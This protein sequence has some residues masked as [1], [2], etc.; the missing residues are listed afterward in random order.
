MDKSDLIYAYA[1]KEGKLYTGQCTRTRSLSDAEEDIHFL[2]A[3]SGPRTTTEIKGDVQQVV[4]YSPWS[5]R[6]AAFRKHRQLASPEF[7]PV[8]GV[9]LDVTRKPEG[10]EAGETFRVRT[11]TEGEFELVDPKPGTYAAQ[12]VA[13]GFHIRTYEHQR[14]GTRLRSGAYPLRLRENGCAEFNLVRERVGSVTVS[15]LDAEGGPLEDTPEAGLFLAP[16]DYLR[17]SPRR[18]EPIS[19]GVFRFEEVP[20]GRYH[21]EVGFRSIPNKRFPYAAL[22]GDDSL[23]QTATVVQV[24]ADQPDQQLKLRV[25]RVE[26]IWISGRVT[27]PGGAGPRQPSVYFERPGSGFFEHVSDRSLSG[28]EFRFEWFRG[29]KVYLQA[30]GREAH[31]YA[32]AKPAPVTP[33]GD[34]EMNFV[35]DVP[36]EPSDSPPT[37]PH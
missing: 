37:H 33:V 24:T 16:S 25:K 23:S 32:R 27:W 35:L 26:P 17:W 15:L 13:K 6:S 36:A 3:Y 20:V 14:F 18:G 29:L 19:P 9:E 4:G 21:L 2:R 30:E 12:V 7:E 11:D 31:R 1:D 28:A 22:V 10:R 5:P 34:T 8:A